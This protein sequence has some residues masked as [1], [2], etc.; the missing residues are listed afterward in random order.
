MEAK[1]GTTTV[2]IVF[3]GGV[4]LG[5]EKRATMANYIASR[6]MKKI[7]PI[8][9]HAAIAVA[10]LVGDAQAIGRILCVEANIYQLERKRK[11]SIEALATLLANILNSSKY[12]PYWI[13]VL[14][15]GYDK[16]PQLFSVDAAGGVSKEKFTSG[17]SGSLIAYGVL[18]DNFKENMNEEEAV[19]LVA[20]ALS[21]AMK[22]DSASGD[23]IDIAIIDKNGLRWVNQEKIK[24]LL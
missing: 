19:Q 6:E 7:I 17:G 24:K 14:L 22:R 2:G 8:Q 13:Q 18:E 4:I 23:G 12:F 3:K 20:R 5:A 11:V 9:D 16:A 1:K 10:G 15:A 21:A